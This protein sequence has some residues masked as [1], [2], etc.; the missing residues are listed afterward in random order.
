MLKTKGTTMAYSCLAAQLRHES[1]R[2]IGRT[3]AW[4]MNSMAWNGIVV[5]RCMQLAAHYWALSV[6]EAF[7]G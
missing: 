5:T 7:L 1:M 2:G 4:E 6:E 3:V